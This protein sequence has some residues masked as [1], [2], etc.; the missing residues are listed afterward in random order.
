MK[1]DG[2]S[3]VAIAQQPMSIVDRSALRAKATQRGSH[4]LGISQ[5]VDVLAFGVWE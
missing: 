2:K 5:R 3:A 4:M 1:R